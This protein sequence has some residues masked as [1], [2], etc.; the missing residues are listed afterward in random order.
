MSDMNGNNG[1]KK[2]SQ[3]KSRVNPRLE[4]ANE[5]RNAV[6]VLS[7][8]SNKTPKRVDL[9]DKVQESRNRADPRNDPIQNQNSIKSQRNSYLCPGTDKEQ[10]LIREA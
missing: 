9:A 6:S 4:M 7:V 5:K 2:Q 8:R 1:K 3:S 10:R